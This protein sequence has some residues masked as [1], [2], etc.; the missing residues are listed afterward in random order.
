VP[1]KHKQNKQEKMIDIQLFKQSY[2]SVKLDIET[3][4]KAEKQK[5]NLSD[6]GLEVYELLSITF[7]N[8]IAEYKLIAE[9]KSKLPQIKQD[10][11]NRFSELI[12]LKYN[13]K[14]EF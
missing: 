11:I 10:A 14:R 7:D 5:N 4:L 3:K 9:N 2:Y 12:I 13:L 6:F 8:F 1:K